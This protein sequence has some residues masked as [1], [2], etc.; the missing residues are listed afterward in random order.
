MKRIIFLHS[1]FIDKNIPA[2]INY[3]DQ[4]K[5]KETSPFYDYINLY[6]DKF[7]N[8]G[9]IF[10]FKDILD[11]N[12]KQLNQIYVFDL[13]RS[14]FKNCVYELSSSTIEQ[15]KNNNIPI[16]FYFASEGFEFETYFW[17]DFIQKQLTELGLEKNLKFL[18]FGTGRSTQYFYEKHIEK[19][20][21]QELRNKY[22]NLPKFGKDFFEL[23]HRSKMT[24]CFGIDWFEHFFWSNWRYT[25]YY[26]NKRFHETLSKIATVEN[27]NKNFVCLNRNLRYQRLALVSELC[28]HNLQIGNHITLTGGSEIPNPLSNECQKVRSHILQDT[29][30][31]RYFNK[32]IENY[33]PIKSMFFQETDNYRYLSIPPLEYYY[34]TFYE[35]VTETEVG[36]NTLFLTEKILKP[37]ALYQ[38]FLLFGN[39][40]SLKY[41]RS[42]GYETFPEMFDESYDEEKSLNKRFNMI[43][44]QVLE[45]RNLSRAKKANRYRSV[46]HKLRHNK[47]LFD[48]R[49]EG[50]THKIT[51]DA[52]DQILKIIN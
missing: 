18:F 3:F 15:L 20:S 1:E 6:R 34:D 43:I 29:K 35:L 9:Y 36:E 45:F 7:E 12:S 5:P 2:V 44:Q 13:M 25:E 39:P 37:I 47:K 48:K 24:R 19:F 8:D 32:F 33:K 10:E 41:L 40:F 27:K 22:N 50:M 14:I 4:N 30:K 46:I 51:I 11:Y 52:L 23:S 26:T 38:P 31:I 49:M 28:R 21:D 42:L 17:I 16:L